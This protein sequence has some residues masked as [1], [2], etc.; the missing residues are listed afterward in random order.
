MVVTCSYN[1]P[2]PK[3]VGEEYTFSKVF[4][5][6]RADTQYINTAQVAASSSDEVLAS[7]TPR[8]A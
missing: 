7:P 2:L 5:V 4:L 8:V 1:I 3:R 6:E